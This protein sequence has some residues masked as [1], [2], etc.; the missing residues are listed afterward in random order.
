[1]WELGSSLQQVKLFLKS[2][3]ELCI[4]MA[5]EKNP[6]ENIHVADKQ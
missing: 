4:L 2:L 6:L 3:E 1:M 5:Y